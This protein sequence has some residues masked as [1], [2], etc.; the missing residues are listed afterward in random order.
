MNCW[1]EQLLLCGAISDC[2]CLYFTAVVHRLATVLQL[3]LHLCSAAA[4][5]LLWLQAVSLPA[6]Q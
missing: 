6:R 4:A 1:E 2:F 3:E 5:L